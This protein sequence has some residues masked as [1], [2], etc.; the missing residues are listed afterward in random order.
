VRI[1][2]ETNWNTSVRIDIGAYIGVYIQALG[3]TNGTTIAVPGYSFQ[4][5]R[6]NADG[7]NTLIKDQNMADAVKVS[8]AVWENNSKQTVGSSVS[9][10]FLVTGLQP[11]TSYYMETRH[12]V[13]AFCANNGAWKFESNRHWAC[14]T[15]LS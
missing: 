7:S 2:F 14:V 13:Q 6:H 11:Y 4:V 5:W 12:C 1:S 3:S 15:P 10:S 8:N 9:N